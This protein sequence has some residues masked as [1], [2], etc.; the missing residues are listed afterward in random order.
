MKKSNPRTDV[1]AFWILL[2]EI[3]MGRN[4]KKADRTMSLYILLSLIKLAVFGGGNNG[5]RVLNLEVLKGI[6]SPMEEEEYI[7]RE[8]SIVLYYNLESKHG[9]EEKRVLF[10]CSF[11]FHIVSMCSVLVPK[12]YK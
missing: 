1:Y 2:L 3:L 4:G 9:N 6:K 8:E 12:L 10:L 11:P 5:G 7:V